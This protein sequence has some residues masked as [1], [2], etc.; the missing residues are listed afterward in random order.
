MNITVKAPSTLVQGTT[1]YA[2]DG[3]TY[4]IGAG[5]IVTIDSKFIRQALELGFTIP[6]SFNAVTANLTALAGG[7]QTGATALVYGIN[8]LAT[9]ATAA[10]SC[11]LPAAV[12]GEFVTIVNDGVAACQVF[13]TGADTINGIAAAT[14]LSQLPNSVATYWCAVAGQ[15][16][17]E[18]GFGFSGNFA[19]IGV[20]ANNIASN[21]TTQANGT[22]L[23]ATLNRV[24][25][26]GA[27]NGAVVLPASQPGMRIRVTNANTANAVG[28]FPVA[29]EAITPGAANAVFSVPANKTADFSCAVAK[30]WDAL[31]SA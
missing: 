15:W 6:A 28:V 19:T 5:G 23:T 20:S 13:G 11:M 3:T 1:F 25:S 10:D 22:P 24:A 29:N 31:L 30:Q 18:P 14:G 12:P 26:V 16:R 9:V 7:G 27:A 21:G 17:V 2:I 8:Q 4:T